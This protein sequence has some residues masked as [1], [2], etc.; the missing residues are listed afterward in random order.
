M[1]ETAT[2]VAEIVSFRLVKGASAPEF[3]A[4]ARAIEPLLLATGHV[5]S[6]VLSEA[7]DGTW[8]DHITWTSLQAAKT[9]AQ[10][11]MADPAAAP[12]MGLIDPENMSMRHAPIR[13]QQE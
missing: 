4:A 8:T 12:M 10:A 6:R 5:L 7:E 3:I 13:Y 1:F 11:M 2:P 9:T